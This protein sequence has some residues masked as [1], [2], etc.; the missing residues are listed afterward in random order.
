MNH[1][2]LGRRGEYLARLYM[3]EN[4]LVFIR[5]NYATPDGEIDLIMRDD[6]EIVFVEVKTRTLESARK[7]GRGSL[8]IDN[9]K[10]R[11]LTR[12]AQ[13]FLREEKALTRGLYPRFDVV[14]VY[15]DPKDPRKAQVLHTPFAFGV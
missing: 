7:Y 9:A 3:E 15:L 12:A 1:L 13:Q 10:E 5:A 8:R 4:G 6:A 2:D 11:H 14:E